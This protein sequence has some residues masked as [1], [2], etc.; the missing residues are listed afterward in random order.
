MLREDPRVQQAYARYR[1][2]IALDLA[3]AALGDA[4]PADAVALIRGL[5][6]DVSDLARVV[7]DLG[8]AQYPWLPK[9]LFYE[10]VRASIAAET[11]DA[12]QVDVSVPAGL[13]WETQGK[14]PKQ[15][16]GV[17]GGFRLENIKRNI[18]WF[19]RCEVL[20]KAKKRFAREQGTTRSNLQKALIRTRTLLD[21]VN[22]PNPQQ[23]TPLIS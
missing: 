17:M 23:T 20:K 2:R 13:T 18:T 6:E 19:V 16:I 9:M 21:C 1:A 22:A 14:R 5:V 10:F 3:R 4:D 7:K 11:G 15:R 8:L 12:V